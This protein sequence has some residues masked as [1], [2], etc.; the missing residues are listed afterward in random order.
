MI[1]GFLRQFSILLLLLISIPVFAQ[2]DTNFHYLGFDD[3]VD[4]GENWQEISK[5]FWGFGDYS[6]VEMMEEGD[7]VLVNIPTSE[8]KSHLITE[9][10]FGDIELSLD[11]MM[12]HQSNSG[13]Y[14]MGRYEVQLFDSWRKIFPTYADCGGIYQRWDDNQEFNK[15]YEGV[16]PLLNAC[17]APGLWQN[18]RILFKAPRFD[19][20]GIKISNA[21]FV[22]VYLNDIL[23]QDEVEIS[24]PTRSTYFKN[25]EAFG[26]LMIQGDHGRVAIRNLKYRELEIIDTVL[27]R[28]VVDPIILRPLQEPYILRSFLN[29]KDEKLPYVVSVGYPNG[30][31]YSFDTRQGSLL[32]VWRGDF[33]ET[34]GMWHRRGNSQVAKPL[35][36]V[37]HLS[38]E[39]HLYILD[40]IY[41]PWVDKYELDYLK[42]EGYMLDE[43]RDPTFKFRLADIEISDK[44]NPLED[45]SG[46]HRRIQVDSSLENLV[47]RLISG[48]I[49]EKINNKLYRVDDSYYIQVDDRYT[50]H[51][52]EFDQKMEL[53]VMM[54]V[55]G[56]DLEY[57]I[58]W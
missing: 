13:I 11:F 31:N 51:L 49:I 48:E 5:I 9:S 23:I 34:T 2:I 8:D 10:T 27:D 36:S 58:I 26:P 19:E 57:K 22:K 20:N 54:Q 6:N 53:R 30:V 24:G 41:Q 55:C 38:D 15:G 52:V 7:G 40:N 17:R 16:P 14:L 33:V 44:I 42:M 28:T 32:Q 12:A 3:F 56:G 50:I 21:R 47:C 29:Y 37:V 35:G 46:L 4:V 25:E 43:D 45:Q 1:G 18:L 39:P